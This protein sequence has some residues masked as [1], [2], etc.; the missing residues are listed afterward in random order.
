MRCPICGAKMVQNQLCQYCNI[1]DDQVLNASNK[2]VKE[3]RKEDMLDLVHFTTV[4]P[5]DVSKWKLI[6][7]TI[8]LGYIGINHYYVN[9]IHR[10]NFSLVISILSIVMT[11]LSLVASTMM[12]MLFF[13][14][15]FELVFYSMAINIILWV[16]DI[17]NVLIKKFKVPVVLA[18]KENIK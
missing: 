11:I 10:A 9:R 6:L 5:K 3:Y 17:I 13:K 12:S 16:F 7:Y 15:I 14:L 18:E 4:V 8:L 1:T 2:K